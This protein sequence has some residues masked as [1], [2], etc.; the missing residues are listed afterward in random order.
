MRVEDQS[1]EGSRI[2]WHRRTDAEEL[3][4]AREVGPK[5]LTDRDCRSVGLVARDNHAGH[6]QDRCNLSSDRGEELF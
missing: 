2:W 3:L 1:S 4:R 6:I 5:C